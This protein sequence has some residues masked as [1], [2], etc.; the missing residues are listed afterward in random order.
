VYENTS[1]FEG[2]QQQKNLPENS[3]NALSDALQMSNIQNFAADDAKKPTA[4]CALV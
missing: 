2:V 1:F 4:L 3:G